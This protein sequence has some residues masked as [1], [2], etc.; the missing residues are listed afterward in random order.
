MGGAS[1]RPDDGE[2]APG[3]SH[4]D[5]LP[6]E[7]RDMVVDATRLFPRLVHGD[8]AAAE[9]RFLTEPQLEELWTDVCRHG[10]LGDLAALPAPPRGSQCF[11]AVRS[12]AMLAH[13]KAA[14]VADAAAL[15]LVA[16]RN[17]WTDQL[18]FGRPLEL[19]A[20]AAYEGSVALLA[21]LVEARGAVRPSVA[22]AELAAWGGHLAAVAW[23]HERMAG[24]RWTPAVT[25]YAAGSGSLAL[26]QWLEAHRPECVSATAVVAAARNGHQPVAVRMALQHGHAGVL[27]ALHARHPGVLPALAPR[28]VEAAGSAAAL[29]VVHQHAGIAD[30]RALLDALVR[31]GRADAVAW[32]CG[33]LGLRPDQPMLLAACDGDHGALAAWLVAQPRIRIDAAAVGRA[34]ARSAVAVLHVF[35]AHGPAARAA[36]AAQLGEAM[37]MDLV[38][39]LHA[40]HPAVFTQV[41]LDGAMRLGNAAVVAYL[42]DHVDGVGWDTARARKHAKGEGKE[43]L[44]AL[45]EAY[46]ARRYSTVC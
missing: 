32:A 29:R 41:A 6:Q 46:S 22:L 30:P 38:Q 12:R 23:L 9:L 17:G 27:A 31:R 18:D 11:G 8:L 21:D 24:V 13:L 4:W 7:L 19:A 1:S 3:R 36:V 44:V 16:V 39:W 43:H 20:A 37:N 25:E 2:L 15:R 42:L 45:L 28:D 40:R 14:G 33:A 5:R 35:V 26:V 34:I 10:W